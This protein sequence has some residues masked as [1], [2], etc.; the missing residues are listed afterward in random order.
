MALF[1]EDIKGQNKVYV[2]TQEKER[3][4]R[5]KEYLDN[6]LENTSNSKLEELDI[7]KN[8]KTKG[9]DYFEI[10]TLEY[11]DY[12]FNDIA[13]EFKNYEDFKTSIRDGSLT[14]QIENL[15]VHSGFKDIALVIVCDDPI[16]FSND[17]VQWKGAIR[18]GEKC[19]VIIAKDENTA[20]EAI[21][22]LFWLNSRHLSQPPRSNMKK[23]DN[24]AANL[25]WATR[26]LS[27][28]QVREIIRKTKIT[29]MPQCINLFTEFTPIELHDKLNIPRLTIERLENCRRVLKGMPLLS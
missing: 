28:K 29:T 24:Y 6:Y 15:Y 20:F 25:L 19:N 23:S 3:A 22:H 9:E 27:D 21:C 14:T 4:Y 8:K 1:Y 18:F 13:I 10:A 11:G 5:F 26:T 2:D 17:K 12:S 7:L 16:H